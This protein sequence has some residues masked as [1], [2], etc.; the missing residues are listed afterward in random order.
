MLGATG[1]EV[2][3]STA[4]F[5]SL[6]THPLID[7]VDL[8]ALRFDVDEWC[9]A[10]SYEHAAISKSVTSMSAEIR[11]LLSE[12]ASFLK[13]ALERLAQAASIPDTSFESSCAQ[14]LKATES[15]KIT[16]ETE[17]ARVKAALN[18]MGNRLFVAE[19][20]RR[21][22]ERELDMNTTNPNGLPGLAGLGGSEKA[23]PRGETKEGT[24]ATAPNSVEDTAVTPG[25]VR[26]SEVGCSP[27]AAAASG[28]QVTKEAEAARV[29]LIE[30]VTTLKKEV[31]VLT[32]QLSETEIRKAAVE[33]D[34]NAQLSIVPDD[35]KAEGEKYSDIIQAI[36]SKFVDH[37]KFLQAEVHYAFLVHCYNF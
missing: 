16:L 27:V 25:Q 7:H 21:K 34:L 8:N 13:R 15:Q 31:E 35:G 4:M 30:E 12:R 29:S 26:A 20:R 10:E 5:L 18:D 9:P 2:G 32:K 37:I 28:M 6:G 3:S 33:S 36:K 17:L 11:Q 19:K 23:Q 1:V 22:A 14:M 24:A